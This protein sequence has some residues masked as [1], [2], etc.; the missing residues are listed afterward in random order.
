MSIK[1]IDCFTFYNELDVLTYRLNVLNDVVDYFVIVEST[2][3]FTGREKQL[4]FNENKQL[5]SEFNN[6]II[7]IIVDDIPHKYPNIN[8]DQNEQWINETFQRDAI[9]RG[10]DLINDLNDRD[11]IIISDLDEISDP[12]T[13]SKIKNNDIFVTVNKLEQDMYYYNLN[14]R[15]RIKWYFSKILS[16]EKYKELGI[17]CANIRSYSNS[18]IISNGG[19]HLS[20]FGDFIFIQNKIQNF[21]HQ[22]FN[23]PEYTD[24]N[25]IEERVKISE[26]LYDRRRCKFDRIEI[27]DNNY[28]PTKY[29]KYLTNFF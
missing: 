22:E 11:C 24:L 18:P 1:I 6:K 12:S 26:D 3:T 5:F 29:E 14:T 13:L 7:H 28:L 19:W 27:K 15:Y 2:H 16:Y 9:S 25:K 10:L 4:S 20:Y 17:T 21:S 8:I 23:R